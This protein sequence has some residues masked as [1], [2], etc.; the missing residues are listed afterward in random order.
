MLRVVIATHIPV[1]QNGLRE[2]VN[3]QA[4]LEF[5]GAI[6]SGYLVERYC[7]QFNPQVVVI[8]SSLPGPTLPALIGNLT[9]RCPKAKI[10]IFSSLTEDVN[11]RLLVEN[12]AS[13]CIDQ[14]ESNFLISSA[15]RTIGFGA[16]WFS[17]CCTDHLIR[18]NKMISEHELTVREL[19]TVKLLAGGLSNREIAHILKVT[20]RT[21]EFHLSNVF[22][23]LNMNNR[24]S[25]ALW[26]KEHIP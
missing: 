6:D 13:G 19:E 18:P 3:A 21:V 17:Q 25:V 22:Q 12:G 24:V 1:V 7:L 10:L 9:S 26:A 23:K 2:I 14:E 16:T 8:S 15:I 5:V 20:N 11:I 4:D